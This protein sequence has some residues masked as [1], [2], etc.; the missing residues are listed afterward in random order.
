MRETSTLE[1]RKLEPDLECEL[2]EFFRAL[3]NAE[4]SHWFHPHP[5]TPEEAKKRCTYDGKDFYC[6]ALHEN[7]VLAYGMLRG[8]DE[9]FEV[10]SLGIAVHPTARGLGL[11]R[12][13]MLF[14]QAAASLRG[15]KGIRLKVYPENRTAVKLYEK[16]GYRYGEEVEGQLIGYL[17][18]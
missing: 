13:F 12:A 1:F 18:I 9:G 15:A 16:L 2:A 5:F 17:E 8:W 11:G 7:K 4:D 10:P 6:V 3:S 14:L